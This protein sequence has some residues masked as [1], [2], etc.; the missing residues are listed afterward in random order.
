MHVLVPVSSVG[1]GTYT[2]ELRDVKSHREVRIQKPDLVIVDQ[3]LYAA[4]RV[5]SN[6]QRSQLVDFGGRSAWVS[7]AIPDTRGV[8][9]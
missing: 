2:A 3:R 8:A 7:E 4:G 6:E 9:A 5:I 1:L